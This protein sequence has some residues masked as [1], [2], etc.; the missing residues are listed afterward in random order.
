MPL[1]STRGGGSSRGYG[2]QGG[3]SIIVANG[4]TI[5]TFT[6]G[7]EEYQ[8]HKFNTSGNFVVEKV[9]S[10]PGFNTMNRFIAGGGGSG[11]NSGGNGGSGIVILRMATSNYSGTQS[12]GTVTT[13]GS[14][15]IISY[16]TVASNHT[17]TA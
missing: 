2:F 6:D 4:G 12:G 15:T 7:D 14:D 11:G 8:L 1:L 13:D 17:Y 5:S 3:K 16:T 10:K 9:P